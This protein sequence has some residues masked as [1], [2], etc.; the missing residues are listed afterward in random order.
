MGQTAVFPDRVETGPSP[1]H[2][3]RERPN[4]GS[5]WGMLSKGPTAQESTGPS[6]FTLARDEVEG[7]RT[8]G[9]SKASKRA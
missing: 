7:E 5:F 2:A 8:P 4:P 1:D 9:G 3:G 6:S